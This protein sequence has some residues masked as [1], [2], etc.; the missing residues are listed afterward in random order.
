MDRDQYQELRKILFKT[1]KKVETI[2]TLMVLF[3]IFGVVG[4]C[5]VIIGSMTPSL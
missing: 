3:F 2:V 4:S 5:V 1:Y